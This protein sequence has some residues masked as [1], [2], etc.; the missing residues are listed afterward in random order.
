MNSSGNLETQTRSLLDELRNIDKSGFLDLGHPLLNR[1]ADSFVKA[2]G[3]GAIQAV[4]R[5][6]YFTAIEG[7]GLNSGGSPPDISA[8]KRHR[9]PHLKG[10]C[11]KCTL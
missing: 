2:A 5:E 1:I 10:S 11:K 9:F 8:P 7:A 6:A 3:I 4:T